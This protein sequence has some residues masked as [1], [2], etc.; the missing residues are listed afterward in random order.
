MVATYLS[1]YPPTLWG[2]ERKGH[3]HPPIYIYRGMC[4]NMHIKYMLAFIKIILFILII[5]LNFEEVNL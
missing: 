2:A 1:V 5:I 4:V 3:T